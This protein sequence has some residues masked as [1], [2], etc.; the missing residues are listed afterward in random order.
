[1][2]QSHGWEQKPDGGWVYV[3]GESLVFLASKKRVKHIAQLLGID[4]EQHWN[5]ATAWKSSAQL[6]STF[7]LSLRENAARSDVTSF[8]SSAI[9]ERGRQSQVFGPA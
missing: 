5:I 6:F 1:M 7:K 9:P 2:I 8:R 3:A 4:F